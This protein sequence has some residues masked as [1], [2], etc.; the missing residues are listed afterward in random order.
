[1]DLGRGTANHASVDET[2]DGRFLFF[3]GF[4]QW[5]TILLM[6]R[7]VLQW[8]RKKVNTRVQQYMHY[9]SLPY[10]TQCH[11]NCLHFFQEI[12]PTHRHNTGTTPAQHR[13]NTDTPFWLLVWGC[14]QRTTK[15]GMSVCAVRKRDV[16]QVKVTCVTSTWSVATRWWY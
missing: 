10:P 7:L 5:Y 3:S 12:T 11:A 16:Q 2:F 8:H 1:M 15:K 13:H 14:I 4:L 6:R 9:L